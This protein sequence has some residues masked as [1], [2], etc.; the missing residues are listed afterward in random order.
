MYNFQNSMAEQCSPKTIFFPGN[1]TFGKGAI[2]FKT[3]LSSN[4]YRILNLNSKH[5]I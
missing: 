5:E 3:E 4:G 2:K 1:H